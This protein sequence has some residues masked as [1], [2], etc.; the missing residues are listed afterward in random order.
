[1]SFKMINSA[2]IAIFHQYKFNIYKSLN[3]LSG[4]YIHRVLSQSD[5]LNFILLCK[6][7]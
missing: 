3:F 5:Q 7:F 2:K 6:I 1:M 4:R